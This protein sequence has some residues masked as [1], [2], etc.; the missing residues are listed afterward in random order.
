MSEDYTRVSWN[1]Q[2]EDYFKDTAEKAHGRS[3]CHKKG[4]EIYSYRRTLIDLPVIIGSGIIAFLN[5][6]STSLFSDAKTA[7]ISLGVGS[8]VI[9]VLNTLGTYYSWAKRAEGHRI[10]S[11]QYARQYRFLRIQLS[12]PRE[13]R[14]TPPDLLKSVK[15]SEDRLQEIS[16][17]LPPE[18]IKLF[19]SKFNGENTIA[20]P[21]EANGLEPVHIF[22]KADKT[23]ATSPL[24]ISVPEQK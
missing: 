11:L 6:G 19:Q 14:L 2:I 23:P 4:E 24:T 8:L 15:D 22:T 10:A 20:K 18:V 21:E 9:G 16:P 12:L 5:A 13:E 17:L 3:W 1:S 7:S